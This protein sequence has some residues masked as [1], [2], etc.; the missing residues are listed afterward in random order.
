MFIADQKLTVKQ[1]FTDNASFWDELYAEGR[2]TRDFYSHEIKRRKDVV[3]NLLSKFMNPQYE[4]AIDVG[5]GAG[6]YVTGLG[7]YKLD[8]Y[9]SDISPKMI[10]LTNSRINRQGTKNV[11]LLC[12]DCEN[13]PFPDEYF[14]VVLCIGVLSYVPDELMILKELRRIVKKDGL[15]IFNVPNVLK[16]RNMLDPYYYIF[17]TWS[18]A[19]EKI[20]SFLNNKIKPTRVL[21]TSLMETPQNRYTLKQILHLTSQAGL[22]IAEERGYAFGPLRFWRKE[23]MSPK[24]SLKLSLFLESLQERRFFNN[25]KHFP[26]GWVFVARK[27]GAQI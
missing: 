17:K 10:D 2:E 21:D 4:K 1:H 22:E 27:S 18:F 11:K 9:G 8:V 3:L 5:C 15:V 26:V 14:D 16:L 24:T 25:I 13:L 12:A 20:D 19:S 23:I 6:F 7:E